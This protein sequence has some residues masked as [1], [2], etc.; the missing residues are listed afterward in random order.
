MA[1]A[2]TRCTCEA[3]CDGWLSFSTG[4]FILNKVEGRLSPQTR[5]DIEGCLERH[6]SQTRLTHSWAAVAM[7]LLQNPQFNSSLS[8]SAGVAGR[9]GGQTV[10]RKPSK[11]PFLH[12]V[13][14]QWGQSHQRPITTTAEPQMKGS[15]LKKAHAAL[16]AAADTCTP[17]S[18][19]WGSAKRA[20]SRERSHITHAY[21]APG[22]R[23]GGKNYAACSI[24]T[25]CSSE[26]HFTLYFFFFEA[27]WQ[28]SHILNLQYVIYY[29]F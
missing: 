18:S 10:Q 29:Y 19:G 22:A 12:S 2:L 17:M 28:G 21:L 5:P 8:L 25:S 13:T 15:G 20:S 27:G 6:K 24:C 3:P 26:P 11:R 9:A 23:H 4:K 14:T 7:Y 1:A 16:C